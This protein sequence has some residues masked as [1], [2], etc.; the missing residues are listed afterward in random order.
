MVIS[1]RYEYVLG[2]CLY[3]KNIH[4][5]THPWHTWGMLIFLDPSIHNDISVALQKYKR[6]VPG[7]PKYPT[8]SAYRADERT[9]EWTECHCLALSGKR[10]KLVWT[11]SNNENKSKRDS[12][13]RNKRRKKSKRLKLKSVLSCI[14]FLWSAVLILGG[15]CK[16][17]SFS[18]LFGEDEP[19]LTIIFQRGWLKPPTACKVWV[20]C[21]TAPTANSGLWTWC[22]AATTKNLRVGRWSAWPPRIELAEDDETYDMWRSRGWSFSY[23]YIFTSYLYVSIHRYIDIYTYKLVGLKVGLYD[24]TKSWPENWRSVL[25]EQSVKVSSTFGHC[26]QNLEVYTCL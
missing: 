19:I 13:S 7:I 9:R 14:I 12:R 26:C 23:I 18:P 16:Y 25:I 1:R 24:G 10:E 3:L 22:T 4:A 21:P 11:P 6:T 5:C 15:G 17:P 20:A 2:V 8:S